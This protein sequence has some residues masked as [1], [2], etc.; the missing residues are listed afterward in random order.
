MPAQWQ[1]ERL[2]RSHERSQFD[3]GVAV[4]NDWLRKL[5]SQY[6]KRDLARTYVA[7]EPGDTLVRGYYAISNHRVSYDALPDDQAK[8]LPHIDVPVVLLGRLAV[9]QSMQGQGLGEY[10]LLDALRRASYIADQIGVRAVEVDA[11]DDAAQAF[12]VKYGFV[13]LRDDE[14]H[15]FLPMRVIR[16][17]KLSPL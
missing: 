3:C 10:L 2:D 1:I 14:R 16:Q 7:V 12:Y 8:G 4:L 6:E 11:I 5:V 17:L 13:P 9:D 15:L